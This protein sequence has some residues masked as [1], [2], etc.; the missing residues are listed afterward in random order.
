MIGLPDVDEWGVVYNTETTYKR[1]AS[2][3]TE[4]SV[5]IAWTDQEGT[6]LDILLT[7]FP[8]QVGPLQ[9]GL[10]GNRD[11]F[12]AVM[13]FGAHS[14]DAAHTDTHGGYI[15]EKLGGGGYNVTWEKVAE[16]LNGIRGFL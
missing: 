8:L 5:V 10:R 7:L 11:L 6:Q 14:F 12:V 9:R 1:L 16:L 15:S 13:G 2:L 3:L 4:T